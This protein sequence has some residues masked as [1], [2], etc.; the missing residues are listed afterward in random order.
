MLAE[1]IQVEL[2]GPSSAD[3][4]ITEK[5]AGQLNVQYMPLS[6]GDYQLHLKYKNR[7]MSGSPLTVK[8]VGDALRR[9]GI[10]L[11]ARSETKLHAT[12]VG[13][14]SDLSAT[15]KSPSGR[16]TP[17][18]LKL[19]AQKELYASINPREAGDYQVDP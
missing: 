3:V 11:A 6:P 17:V 13:D 14:V 19:N 7:E 9:T 16:E 10:T 2:E 4:K 5:G 1:D 12:N 8:V 15:L 18:S